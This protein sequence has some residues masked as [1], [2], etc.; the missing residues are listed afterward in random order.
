M[1]RHS[2]FLLAFFAAPI[3]YADAYKCID[4]QGKTS[5]QAK[6]CNEDHQSVQ[7]NF[8]TG[9]AIDTSEESR[10][11]AEQLESIKQKVLT[12]QE[13]QQQQEQLRTDSK[14]ET[15]TNQTLIKNNPVQFTAYAI[16]PYDYDNL[17]PLVKDFQSRLPEI[18]RMRRI[19]AQKFLSSG[20]CDRVEASELNI[21]SKMD[22]LVFLVDCSNGATAYF[23][24]SELQ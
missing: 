21:R 23:N 7:I 4:A 14:K 6:P 11:E 9:G 1:M 17:T 10:R 2:I 5:Y 13:I 12:E 8:K 16:P 24:E 19:A 15:D 18:E 20:S 3:A 22:N